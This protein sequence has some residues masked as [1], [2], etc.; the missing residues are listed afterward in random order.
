MVNMMN[1]IKQKPAVGVFLGLLVLYAVLP[2]DTFLS[3]NGSVES[4]DFG[5]NEMG[6]ILNRVENEEAHQRHI[7]EDSNRAEQFIGEMSKISKEVL[8]EKSHNGKSAM[9]II[10]TG[11]FGV[12]SGFSD[13]LSDV[14]VD[15]SPNKEAKEVLENVKKSMGG[16][17]TN[18]P[19]NIAIDQNRTDDER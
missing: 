5:V 7:K 19:T 2:Y 8:T 13:I 12:A 14:P 18:M 3:P 17:N 6:L 10:A 16:V 4:T 15:E 11:P 9:D 1:K